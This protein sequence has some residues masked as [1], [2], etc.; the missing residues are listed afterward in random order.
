MSITVTYK[1]FVHIDFHYDLNGLCKP[2]FVT[3]N[4]FLE[5]QISATL[6]IKEGAA[7]Y[8]HSSRLCT[9]ISKKLC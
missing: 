9:A 6:E 2:D 7:Y 4:N 8:Y 3:S 1:I 5:L